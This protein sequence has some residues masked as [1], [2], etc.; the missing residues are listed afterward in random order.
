MIDLFNVGDTISVS[1]V[2]TKKFADGSF[3]VNVDVPGGDYAFPRSAFW[4]LIKRAPLE[5]GDTV[6]YTPEWGVRK[7]TRMTI[8]AINEEKECAWLSTPNN[9]DFG[10]ALVTINLKYL[11]RD[12]GE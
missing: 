12:T 1:G 6:L 9:S 8:L 2:V 10:G 3:C 11:T 4:Q 5:V 7:S